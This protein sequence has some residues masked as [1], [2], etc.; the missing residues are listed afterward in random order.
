MGHKL[1]LNLPGT[2]TVSVVQKLAI[3]NALSYPSRL[4]LSHSNKSMKATG[5]KIHITLSLEVIWLEPSKGA[6]H[7]IRVPLSLLGVALL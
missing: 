3:L 2:I 7:R 1:L 5:L 6:S 4:I